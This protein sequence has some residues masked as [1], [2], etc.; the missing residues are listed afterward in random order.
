MMTEPGTTPTSAHGQ[1]AFGGAVAAAYG[2]L[3]VMHVVFG[4]FFAL[5][6]IC[7]VRGVG[8]ALGAWIGSL[9]RWKELPPRL[10]VP[11]ITHVEEPVLEVTSR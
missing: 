4:L 6:L 1:F 3:M 8:L 11:T 10:A 5:F 2:L 9:E 7:G